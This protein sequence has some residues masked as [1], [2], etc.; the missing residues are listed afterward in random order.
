MLL[1]PFVPV[2]AAAVAARNALYDSGV[3]RI[4]TADL[5]V[6]SVGNLTTGGTG[7]TPIAREIARR[8]HGG[9]ERPAI[10]LRGYRASG[11][12]EPAPAWRERIEPDELA[13]WG[14][15]ALAH[16]RALPGVLVFAHPDRVRAARLARERGATVVVLDDGFQHR[17]LARGLDIV[18]LDWLNPLGKPPG[19]LPSGELREPPR[20][21]RRA[22]AVMWTRWEPGGERRGTEI[23]TD[24]VR[25]KVSVRWRHAAGRMR[26]A[27]SDAPVAPA[28][29]IGVAGIARP[30]SFRRTLEAA[31]CDVRAFLPYPDHHRFPAALVAGLERTLDEAGAEMIVTTEKDE[32]RLLVTHP[33]R[34][35]AKA[36]RLAVLRLVIEPVDDPAALWAALSRASSANRRSDPRT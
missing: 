34:A 17:H 11:S 4:V 1:A 29:T 27:G 31:G 7:K 30:F 6:V 5:P 19:L 20:A 2:Y 21:L 26:L 15:E 8:L 22:D 35:L 32:A 9:G 18:C 12:D 3:R 23:L 16:A 14:D 36:G 10:L 33:G 24:L 28:R 13:R 25:D